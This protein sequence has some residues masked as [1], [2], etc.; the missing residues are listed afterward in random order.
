MQEQTTLNKKEGTNLLIQ[1]LTKEVDLPSFAHDYD[2][3][4]DLRS[5][6][7]TTI[8]PKQKIIVKTGL[9]VAIPI[10]YAGLI[11]D[12]SG[13]A[14]KHSIHALAG[15]I[16]AGYRGEIGVVLINL[17]DEEF[18]IEKNSRVAQMLIQPVL[19]TE[20][21]EVE[22]LDETSRGEDGFGS[23]GYK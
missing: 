2:A 3:A 8:L 4:I 18:K 22:E 14:A 21:I 16:D 10:G 9:K 19:N 12:R 13:M 23:T 6:E 20:V 15:V 1:R 7:E 17:G 5:A 11:W